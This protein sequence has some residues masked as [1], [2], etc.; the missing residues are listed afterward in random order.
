VRDLP[1]GEFRTT[2]VIEFYGLRCPD[3]GFRIE[4]VDQLPSKAPFSKRFRRG[5]GRGLRERFDAE[6]EFDSYMHNKQ[7][8]KDTRAARCK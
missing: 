3:C 5:R 4:R 7:R 8:K 1:W 2:V 6:A